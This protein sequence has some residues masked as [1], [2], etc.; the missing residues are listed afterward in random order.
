MER[1][2]SLQEW[3]VISYIITLGLEKVRQI[4]MSEPGKLKQK[5]N[6]WMEDYWNITD[7]AA[8]AVFLLGLLLRLQSEP[9]MGYGRVIYCVDIIFWYIRVLD[10]FGVNKY[11]GPYVMMIGKMVRHS[12]M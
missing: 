12:Y 8:I 10:I 1:W 11:L 7:M 9:S 2:P 3:I 5:I 6:V 4:L